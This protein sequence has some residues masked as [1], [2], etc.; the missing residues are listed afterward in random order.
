MYMLPIMTVAPHVVYPSFHFIYMPSITFYSIWMLSIMTVDLYDVCPS[1][2]SAYM[3]FITVLPYIQAVHHG[4]CFMGMLCIQTGIVF[5]WL[6][7][8]FIYQYCSG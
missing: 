6:L 2:C 5:S 7:C 3:L 1:S 4:F 8:I